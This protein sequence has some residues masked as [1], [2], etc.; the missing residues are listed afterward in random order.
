MHRTLR[1]LA[2]FHSE[3][4]RAPCGSEVSAG[5]EMAESAVGTHL[6]G[7]I[8]KGLVYRRAATSSK[9]RPMWHYYVSAEGKKWL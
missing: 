6:R 8:D 2:Q 3:H 7:M 4:G 9:D 5:I 1:F